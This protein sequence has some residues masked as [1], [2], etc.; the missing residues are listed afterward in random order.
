M[1]ASALRLKCVAYFSEVV[2]IPDDVVDI[3]QY[4]GTIDDLPG[5]DGEVSLSEALIAT[6]NTPT[7]S[8]IVLSP[9]TTAEI[10]F[11]G[12]RSNFCQQI[13]AAAVNNTFCPDTGALAGAANIVADPQGAFPNQLYSIV[14]RKQRAF[15][16]NIGAAP[17][18]PRSTYV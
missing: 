15:V 4:A 18:P 12:N 3:D 13:N 1:P 10:G 6:N 16:P 8:K 17:E 2:T 5:P 11:N 14:I 7:I 9:F